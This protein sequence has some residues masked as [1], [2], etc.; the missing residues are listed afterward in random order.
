LEYRCKCGKNCRLEVEP[1]P[2]RVGDSL[3][4]RHCKDDEVHTFPGP[5]AAW[6]EEHPG[7]WVPISFPQ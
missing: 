5:F 6:W 1:M 2:L 4:F 7:Q 3:N